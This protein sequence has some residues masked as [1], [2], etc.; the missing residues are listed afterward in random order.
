MSLLFDREDYRLL[1]EVNSI[2]GSKSSRMVQ[3]FN[4][5]LHPRGIKELSAPRGMRVACAVGSILKSLSSDDSQLRLSALRSLREEVLAGG[6]SGMRYN[7]ARVLTQLMKNLVRSGDDKTRQLELI[8]DFRSALS[9]KP[10]FIRSLLKRYHLLEMPEDYSSCTFDDHVHDASTKGRKSP[11]H[12]ILDAWIKGVNSLLVI[13]YNYIRPEVAHELITAAEILGIKV[14]VGIEFPVRF[15]SKIINIIWSPQ[16]FDGSKEFIRFINTQRVSQL[17]QAGKTLSVFQQRQV[18]E[19]IDIL[20][21]EAVPEL[22]ARF[23]I[24]MPHLDKDEFI[25]FVGEGQA[26]FVHLSE[27]LNFVLTNVLHQ[28]EQA[29]SANGLGNAS[30]ES[31]RSFIDDVHELNTDKLLCDYLSPLADKFNIYNHLPQDGEVAPELYNLEIEELITRIEECSRNNKLILSTANLEAWDVPEIIHRCHGVINC[32]EI[33]NLKDY[34]SLKNYDTSLIN[35]FRLALNKHDITALKRVTGLMQQQLEKA[36]IDCLHQRIEGLKSARR[37]LSDIIERYKGRHVSA[38]VGSDSAGRSRFLYGMGLAVV[39]S[40][41]VGARRIVSSGRERWRKII[42]L[43]SKVMLR[44]TRTELKVQGWRRIFAHFS[45]K[46]KDWLL[47]DKVASFEAEGNIVTL[48]GR[49]VD[50]NDENNPRL[51]P[52]SFIYNWH[53]LGRRYKNAIKIIAG[54]IPAFLTFYFSKDWPILTYGGAL[55]WFGITGIRNVIQAVLGGSG[56]SRSKFLRWRNFIDMSRIADSLMYTGFSVPLLDYLV[57]NLLLLKGLGVTVE[58]NRMAVFAVM[59]LVNGLYISGHNIFRGLPKAAVYGNLVR[60][61]FA[62][63]LAVVYSF[64]VQL[65]LGWLGVADITV[66][67]ELWAAVISKTASDTVACII[68]GLADRSYNLRQRLNDYGEAISSYFQAVENLELLYPED[69]AAQLLDH[70]KR[71]LRSLDE[72]KAHGII[73]GIFAGALDM[74]Y[75]RFCQPRAQLAFIK[76]LDQLSP[77]QQEQLLYGQEILKREKEVTRLLADGFAGK[78]FRG[79]L[80]F[81][82]TNHPAYLEEIDK[83]LKQRTGQN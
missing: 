19:F 78:T 18:V 55:I 25:A 10:S 75:F 54:F 41:P 20:N 39:E 65:V 17:M 50:P 67:L 36:D 62:V 3:M 31:A 64:M 47:I 22:E 5:L 72:R 14:K 16:G 40:L 27:Y 33:F 43:C 29:I 77:D 46:R 24:T 37:N 79:P 76:L 11:S 34:I 49:E 8:S 32:L 26:S 9:G 13:Y 80:A 74:L 15:Y 69:E 44:E 81:Y 56:F 23:G 38:A 58:S 12:L 52:G 30:A 63:P 21:S 82:L 28:K 71:L 68:E 4:P 2:L 61:V 60:A 70:P 1:D 42:P 53:Y 73:R 51:K 66:V 57:K 83:L 48:G 59:A 35:D 7:T 45:A 6:N